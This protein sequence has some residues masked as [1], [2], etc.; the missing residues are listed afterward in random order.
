[1]L[2]VSKM[3]FSHVSRGCRRSTATVPMEE[4]CR[5][6]LAAQGCILGHRSCIL[7]NRDLYSS[8][9]GLPPELPEV[10]L[11]LARAIHSFQ[12]FPGAA[13]ELPRVAARS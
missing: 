1:M 3:M 10:A 5:L 13:Q 2:F 9:Q 4:P 7:A 8:P 12:E 6:H 11:E